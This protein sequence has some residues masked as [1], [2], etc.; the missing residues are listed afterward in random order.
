MPQGFK[1]SPALFQMIMD[2]ILNDIIE[3]KWMVYMDDIIV[4][5]KSEE[6]HDQNLIDVLERLNEKKFKVN[7]S[8]MQFK[9]GK[10]KPLGYM[11]DGI[12]QKPIGALWRF[13]AKVVF[14]ANFL[15]FNF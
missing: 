10:V 13:S 15:L 14:I 8:K 4:Y 1:N 3:E 2:N 6:E 7:S 11:I 9:D 5:G 12:T